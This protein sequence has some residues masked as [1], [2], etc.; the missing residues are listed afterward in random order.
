VTSVPP[1]QVAIDHPPTRDAVRRRWLRALVPFGAGVAALIPVAAAG[2]ESWSLAPYAVM[3]GVPLLAAGGFAIAAA[4]LVTRAARRHPWR[5]ARAR[6][7]FNPHAG[8]ALEATSASGERVRLRVY[9]P[10]PYRQRAIRTVDG[11]DVWVAV[12]EGGF[13]VVAPPPGDELVLV[14]RP[15]AGSTRERRLESILEA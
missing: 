9:T 1:G 5:P 7:V 10:M 3:V 6:H 12:G 2:V 8:S 13:G 11:D 4:V 15:P 14:V